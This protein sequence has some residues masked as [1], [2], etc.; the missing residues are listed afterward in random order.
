MAPFAGRVRHGRFSFEG[1][2]VQLPPT[3]NG[4]AIHGYS[5][6][7]R[8]ERTTEASIRFDFGEPWPFRGYVTQEFQLSEDS[9]TIVMTAH[10]L[11]RQPIQLGW[12]PWFNRTTAAGTLAMGFHA[13]LMYRRDADGMPGELIDVPEGPYD[14]CFT[15]VAQPIT[16]RWG[17]LGLDLTSSADHWVVYDEPKDAVAIEPQTGPPNQLN[18]NPTVVEAG[19]S[20]TAE[21]TL[22]IDDPSL[23][24]PSASSR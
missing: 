8:W 4:H 3:L 12:H 9:L 11:D 1:E 17:T 7:G 21:M 6:L 19:E 2:V 24:S 15:D 13:G 20:F 10:A 23:R 14:D 16:L 18:A 22:S 5:H